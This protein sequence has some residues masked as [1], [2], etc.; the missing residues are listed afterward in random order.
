[1]RRRREQVSG[2]YIHLSSFG[3]PVRGRLSGFSIHFR[4]SLRLL[5]LLPPT[6][7]PSPHQNTFCLAVPIFFFLATASPVY[8][9][10]H[11][12]HLDGSHGRTNCPNLSTFNVPLMRSFLVLSLLVT[13]GEY[14]AILTSVASSCLACLLSLLGNTSSF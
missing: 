3:F 4:Q 6:C 13:P 8:L 7:P 10:P 14:L 11:S 9:C 1:M 5:S 12:H 2:G